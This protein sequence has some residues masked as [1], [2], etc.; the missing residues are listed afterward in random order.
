MTSG[1]YERQNRPRETIVWTEKTKMGYNAGVE[2]GPRR[3]SEE[4]HAT[5]LIIFFI[6]VTLDQKTHV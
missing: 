1:E 6:V 5:E 3:L 4:M 2:R